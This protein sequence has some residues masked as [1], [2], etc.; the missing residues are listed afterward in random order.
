MYCRRRPTKKEVAVQL[1]CSLLRDDDN[2]SILK[3]IV[4]ECEVEFCSEAECNAKALYDDR[5]DAFTPD[6]MGLFFHCERIR[7][8]EKCGR[9]C[10]YP[11]HAL[12][13]PCCDEF[14]CRD[15]ATNVCECGCAIVENENH[16]HCETCMGTSC[17]DC[18][19]SHDCRKVREPLVGFVPTHWNSV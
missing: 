1:L 12:V 14:Y 8:C 7:A 9:N 6:P 13:L 4:K 15:C 11:Q 19:S 18:C 16:P 10:C 3:D 17:S 2:H 5:L